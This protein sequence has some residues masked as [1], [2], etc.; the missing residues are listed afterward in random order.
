MTAH[1]RVRTALPAAAAALA[2]GGA[3]LTAVP[4]QAA[5]SPLPQRQAGQE[6]PAPASQAELQA[7]VDG[8][9]AVFQ[10]DAQQNGGSAKSGKSAE[11]ATGDTSTAPGRTGSADPKVIGGVDASISEAPWMVQ[12]YYFDDHG[13]T[14]PVDDEGYFCGG[15][16]V[17]PAKVLTAAHCVSGLD[18]TKHGTVIGGTEKLFTSGEGAA[19]GVWRQ[20]QNPGYSDATLKGD[21]AVLTLTDTLSDKLPV[22]KTLLPTPSTNTASY[23]PGTPGTV[24]GWGRTSSTSDDISQTLKKATIPVQSDSACTSVY[25]SEFVP[26]QMLCAGNPASGQDS[27][28]ISPCNGDSGG[29]LVVNGR[30]AGVV[31]WGVQDCV[32]TGARSVFAKTSTFAGLINP[33]IDDANVNFDDKADLFTRAST[34]EGFAYMSR[35]TSLGDRVSL[36]DWRGINLVRQADL[37]RDYYQDFVFR[38][39]GGE[40]WWWGY[41][42]AQDAYTDHRIGSGWGSFRNIAVTGDVTGDGF[43]DITANDSAGT[44]WLWTGLG[45]GTFNSKKKIGVGWSTYQV[46]GK[47]DYS[48]DGWPDLLARD[49]QARLWVYKG[50]GNAGSPFS[51]RVQVGH[52]WNFTAYATTG[53]LTGDGR[54][55]FMVRDSSGYLWAYKGTGSASAP[56]AL[57]QRVKVGTGWKSYGLFG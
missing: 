46:Y 30:I 57:A 35:G 50:T 45:N 4:A 32:A 25:G 55:D 6:R 5:E 7:R 14:D 49:A 10:N 31:S 28:T 27:G 47:G 18:W 2:L 36:G 11:G 24:Y 54:A 12:L 44:L 39:D 17:A 42:A 23:A 22:N 43:A 20:W 3:V 52:G 9:K 29:P 40:L 41:D 13:N 56:F 26:G 1:R 8:V 33:R 34:G 38:T 21:V 19:V 53:D 16:L 15:T 48:G 51:A 37:N